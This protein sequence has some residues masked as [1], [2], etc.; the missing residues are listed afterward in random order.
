MKEYVYSYWSNMV[1]LYDKV[2]AKGGFAWQMFGEGP[3]L[4][5]QNATAC[6]ATLRS[7]LGSTFCVR[8]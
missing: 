4:W 2:L 7:W 5:E 1:A 3:T 8:N 6:A